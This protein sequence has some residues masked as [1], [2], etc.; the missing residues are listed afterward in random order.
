MTITRSGHQVGTLNEY[1]A[2]APEL[3]Q[4]SESV[5]TSYSAA[6]ALAMTAYQQLF[7]TDGTAHAAQVATPP[8]PVSG[9]IPGII[10][11][12]HLLKLA[13]RANATDTVSVDKTNMKKSDDSTTPTSVILAAVGDWVLIEHRNDHWLIIAAKSGVVT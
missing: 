1:L 11:Q 2:A 12:R 4:D 6:T 10:G 13:V 8:A 3:L 5:T 9:V 7:S